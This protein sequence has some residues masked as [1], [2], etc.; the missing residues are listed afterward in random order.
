MKAGGRCPEGPHGSRVSVTMGNLLGRRPAAV[1]AAG[2]RQTHLGS[3]GMEQSIPRTQLYAEVWETPMGQLATKYGL[4]RD[5]MIRICTRHQIPRPTPG[6]WTRKRYGVEEPSPL[7]TV[8]NSDLEIVC[9]QKAPARLIGRATEARHAVDDEIDRLIRNELGAPAIEVQPGLQKPHRL[10]RAVVE[11][12][13]QRGAFAAAWG[14]HASLTE[15][16]WQ[17]GLRVMDALVKAFEARGHSACA[18]VDTGALEARVEV[19]NQSFKARIHEPRR[20]EPHVL[21]KEERERKARSGSAW[22]RKHDYRATG[23]LSL[24]LTRDDFSFP[25]FELRDRPK[26]KIE[27]RL[28]RFI[29]ATL[30]EVD[31]LREIQAKQAAEVAA[32]QRATEVQ[33]Q[34]EARQQ[35]L[36]DEQELKA[37]ELQAITDQVER[38]RRAHDIR[39][40]VQEV[41][42]LTA[43]RGD[44]IEP[45]C[46]LEKWISW[47][48]SMVDGMDPIAKLRIPKDHPSTAAEVDRQA[49]G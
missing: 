13:R 46:Q 21:T 43:S 28:N 14:R 15:Q 16:T 41:R 7:P 33:R 49:G 1:A 9:L 40:Y 6:H 36:A 10:I 30:K 4:S 3:P 8:D 22:A 27:D 42:S 25:C 20:M 17:R 19:L 35:E 34:E 23:E 12:A 38:W 29:I 44:S 48:L 37:Q 18:L 32:R 45:G 11:R 31:R 26:V 5:D 2:V 39:A 47:A 24:Q